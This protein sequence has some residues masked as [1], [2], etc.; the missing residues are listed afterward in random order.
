MK[1]L[2]VYGSGQGQTAKIARFITQLLRNRG[3]AVELVDGRAI[4]ATLDLTGFDVVVV[5]ASVNS[6]RFQRYISRF[7]RANR[8]Q[9]QQMPSAFFGVSL[10]EAEPDPVNRAA[11]LHT[12]ERFLKATSWKPTIVASFA[13]SI[14]YLRYPWLMRLIWR[15]LPLPGEDRHP[16]NGSATVLDGFEYTDWS[17]VSHFADEIAALSL[18]AIPDQ[19]HDQHPQAINTEPE[20]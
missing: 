16:T 7:V 9:L 20:I 11:A 13:G 2:I 15:R 4:P 12:I 6:G 8:S 3:D 18:P 17:A 14:A 5:G 1:V 19:Q 10:R